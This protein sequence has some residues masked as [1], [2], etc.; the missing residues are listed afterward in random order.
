M[1]D[2][3]VT[4]FEV[5]R[6]SCWEWPQKVS[7][8]A[9]LIAVVWLAALAKVHGLVLMPEIYLGLGLMVWG[10]YL[11][12]RIMDA[13]RWDVAVPWTARHAFCV[14]HRKFLIWLGLPILAGIVVWLAL[15][16][17]P[18]WL[19]E[20]CRMIGSLVVAYMGW[21]LWRS[22]RGGD[23]ESELPKSIVAAS[24]F[25]L[26]VGAGVFGQGDRYP[27]WVVLTGQSL[28]SGMFAINLLGLSIVE[29]RSESNLESARLNAAYVVILVLTLAGVIWIWTPAVDVEGPLR[30]MSLGVLAAAVV[31][32]A[33]HL[34]R[35]RFSA[36]AYRCWVDAALFWAAVGLWV[37]GG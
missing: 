18:V 23:S 24:L 37:F 2:S 13:R 28:L 17:M 8:E 34:K 10:I 32:G 7:L 35:A 27:D 20:H 9:P 19:F 26:G 4:S 36:I 29:Q 22:G 6:S 14:R 12:E 5:P 16:R 25:A 1:K 3:A 30:Q 21:Q 31:M 11:V 33:F 15:Y